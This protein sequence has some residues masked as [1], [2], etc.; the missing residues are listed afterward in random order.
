[1][2][3]IFKAYDIRGIVGKDLTEDIALKIGRAFVSYLNCRK[4]VIGQDMRPH[5]KLL[6]DA[7]ARGLTRQ[8]ADVISLGLCSTPMSYFANGR[9][10]ADASIMITASHNPAE[11]NGFKLCRAQAVPLS[12][13]TG[14]GDIERIVL[15]SQF[16]QP[17]PK[18]G[19]ISQ[20]D[21]LPEYTAHIHKYA[22]LVRPAGPP[23]S[24]ALRRVKIVAD[25]ANAMGAVEAKALKGLIDIDPLYGDLDGSFPN[26]EANPL[27]TETLAALQKKIRSGEVFA[28]PS[29]LS[30]EAL[31]KTEAHLASAKEGKYDFGAAFD[32]DADRVGFVDENGDIVP[33]DLITALIAQ[34]VLKKE[35]G[36]ILYD[37]RSSWA[38]REVIEENGGTPQ[39]C[40]VG[41]A[42]I[43]QQMREAKAVF[44]GELSGHYYFRDNYYTE[45]AA[46]AVLSIANLISQATRPL[47]SLIAPLKRYFKSP[48][49]NSEVKDITAVFNRLRQ[50]Y[51]GGK[52][53]ELDGLSVEFSDWW[54][55][56]RASN[57]EPL[58]RLNLEAKSKELLD[59]RL[60]E[61][62]DLIRRQ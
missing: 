11:W 38:V 54:F 6:F 51:R 21:I 60:K 36:K 49:I 43:K 24:P 59:Q 45:S 35:K 44:A 19:S 4:I 62:L 58:V 57:T 52:M 23:A 31:A 17:A 34:S 20:Y 3:G 55:N 50:A 32:G 8:G 47:S 39:M 15:K 29:D 46:M 40:R 61:L 25:F 1:M 48:E 5:S 2:A 42:F 30:G 10:G 53:F 12:G 14:I 56:V 26:H 9:L 7:L 27:K 33:M 16:S 28:E 18:P 37:L 22:N 13:E 41:H